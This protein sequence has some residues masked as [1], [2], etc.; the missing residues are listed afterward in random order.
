MDAVS[1][2]ILIWQKLGIPK[3]TQVNNE[4]WLSGGFSHPDVLGQVVRLSLSVGT[5]LAFPSVYHPESNG[6]VERFFQDYD[7]H[8]WDKTHLEDSGDVQRHSQAFYRAY[9]QSCHHST[10][11][12]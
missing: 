5:E 12:G 2:L 1:S 8:V 10:L 4:D 11:N 3:C 7:R 9:R 6:Y